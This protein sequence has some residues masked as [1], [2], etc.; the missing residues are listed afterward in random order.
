MT[1]RFSQFDA[2]ADTY[3]D[4]VN[5]ALRL[6][7]ENRHY[8]ARRRVQWLA[9]RLHVAGAKVDSVLDFGCGTGAAAPLFVEYLSAQR[10]VGIDVSSAS[11]E[12]AQHR[13]GAQQASFCRHKE[14]EPNGDF[15]L[16]YASCVFH[17]IAPAERSG[18]IDSI[19]RSLRP[20]GWFALWEHNPF[21]LGARYV[22]RRV[23]FDADAIPLRP[24]EARQLLLAG[25]F[26]VRHLDFLFLFPRIFRF[27]RFLEPRLTRWPLGAQYVVLGQ[28]SERTQ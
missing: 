11:I 22:M 21:N 28:K 9:G 1:E 25:G 18:A 19:L 23:E 27:L 20:G 8:F 26:E 12:I 4:V 6:S 24:S 13:Y 2:H 7:G 3:D 15:D 14:Y 5:Q 17:H 10:T 16:V